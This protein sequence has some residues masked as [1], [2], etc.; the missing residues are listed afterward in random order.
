MIKRDKNFLIILVALA[1]ALITAGFSFWIIVANPANKSPAAYGGNS[2]YLPNVAYIVRNNV[3]QKSYQTVEQALADTQSGDTVYIIPG[4]NPTIETNC[5]VKKGVTLTL[6]FKATE[7]TAE[8]GVAN[9][10][11]VRN[12]SY[13]SNVMEKMAYTDCAHFCDI[14]TNQHSNSATTCAHFATFADNNQNNLTNRLIIGKGVVLTVEN[15]ATLNVGGI[16]GRT[17]QGLMG[18][19]SGFYSQ[20]TMRKNAKIVS[21]GTIDCLGYIK[22]ETSNNGSRVIVQSGNIYQPFVVYDYGGGTHTTGSYQGGNISP[23]SI[24]DMPNIQSELQIYSDAQLVGYADL[25]TGEKKINIVITT[26][27]IPAQHNMT[28]IKIIGKQDSVINLT[29]GAYVISKYTPQ[30]LNITAQTAAVALSTYG[31]TK[32]K[33]Y[34]GAS[35]GAMEMGITVASISTDISTADVFFPVSWKLDIELY[36]GTYNFQNKMKFLSGAALKVD[37]K[38]TVNMSSQIIFY[39]EDFNDTTG[40]PYPYPTKERAVCEIDGTANISGTFGGYITSSANNAVINVAGTA[41]LSVTSLECK[42]TD[43][44]SIDNNT[45]IEVKETAVCDIKGMDN[46]PNAVSTNTFYRSETVDSSYVWGVVTNPQIYTVVYKHNYPGSPSDGTY[47]I[48]MS[49]DTEVVNDIIAPDPVRKYWK[50]TGWYTDSACNT[51]FAEKEVKPNDTITVYAGW[52]ELQYEFE[53]T[54]IDDNNEIIHSEIVTFTYADIESSPYTL[55][56]YTPSA[57][58]EFVGW[59]SANGLGENVTVINT[60]NFDEYYSGSNSFSVIGYETSKIVLIKYNHIISNGSAT[61]KDPFENVTPDQRGVLGNV[62]LSL[63]DNA[64]TYNNSITATHYF[65]GWEITKDGNALTQDEITKFIGS[66]YTFT[67]DAECGEYVVT[68]KW[69]EKL[70]VTVNAQDGVSYTITVGE[71]TIT[72]TD[73]TKNVYVMSGTKITIKFEDDDEGF[74]SITNESLGSYSNSNKTW[75]MTDYEVTANLSITANGKEPSSSGGGTCIAA[76]TL[77]TLADGTQKAVED[78]TADDVLLVFNHFTGEYEPAYILFLE[79]GEWGYYDVINLEFSDGTATKLIYEHALFDLTL[80]KYVYVTEQNYSEFVGHEFALSAESGYK[81]V[82]LIKA[83]LDE[84][85]TAPYSITTVY[86]FNYFID[87]LFSLPGAIDGLF[88]YFEY[89]DNLQYDEEKMLADIEKYGLYTYEDF[90]EHFSY[91]IFE[92]CIPVKYLK[93]AVGKGMITYEELIELFNK[94]AS[95]LIT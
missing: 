56:G 61:S 47:N 83:S 63:N 90:A 65:V 46:N 32:M 30:S 89:A 57:N 86:H 55:K 67:E 69:A 12:V 92:Y 81:R 40:R 35:T 48:L 8:Y 37:S 34:G 52:E 77:I 24:F 75:T 4:T 85:Y 19:T 10:K 45:K 36:D 13:R 18:H 74:D 42:G 25:F 82:T 41:Q 94:Y 15:G 31:K 93:V 78:V 27:T 28:D 60:D 20:I 79:R 68:A 21:N 62:T 26:I 17:G 87:G 64:A 73:E 23:F 58:K 6:H 72:G 84:E 43:T 80:N 44:N 33:I 5:T 14:G 71:T 59:L 16:V 76:G 29:S 11:G 49:A 7:I 50:F 91:E 9:D 39:Q 66:G 95:D 70:T 51:P 38:A 3:R 53:Y 2:A 88:N 54:V 22:E 1:V